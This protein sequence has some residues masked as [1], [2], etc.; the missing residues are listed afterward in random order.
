MIRK[1]G[2][3]KREEGK[4]VRGKNRASSGNIIIW[5]GKKKRQRK[6]RTRQPG[7]I[8]LEIRDVKKVKERS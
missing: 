4:R 2:D 6:F 5:R 7:D 1:I 3:I 8:I